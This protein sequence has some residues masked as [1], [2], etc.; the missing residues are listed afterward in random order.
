[1][2]ILGL[3]FGHDA[4]VTILKDGKTLLCYEKERTNR[5]KH[6]VG[7]SLADIDLC[8]Q[9]MSLT[10]EEVDYVTLTSTQ[11]VEFIQTDR[12]Q[13]SLA[14]EIMPEHRFPCTLTDKMGIKPEQMNNYATGWL[15]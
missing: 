11:L 12:T 15:K 5:K 10:L 9:D 13:M 1:M 7:L 3:H 8:L 6:A 2:I 14:L 4:S